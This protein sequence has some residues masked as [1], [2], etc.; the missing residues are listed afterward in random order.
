MKLERLLY[1]K[2][3]DV[4][5]AQA[6]EEGSHTL[7]RCLGPVQLVTLGVGCII[8]AGIFVL[9]G[10]AAHEHAGP[11]IVLSFVLAGIVS[12]LAALCYAELASMIPV[13]GSAYTYA[14]ATLGQLFAWIIAWDLIV[15]YLFTASTVA[16]GWSG[17]FTGLMH[18]IGIHV[19]AAWSQA[20]YTTA[21]DGFGLVAT[22]AIINLPAA[23]IIALTSFVLALGVSE[24]SWLNTAMVF[25]KVGVVLLVIVFGF[26][27]V[28]ASNWTPFIPPATVDAATGATHYGM[29]GVVTAAGVI[30][31]A[32]IGFESV[33]TAAQEAVNPQRNMPIGILGALAICTVLYIL[34]CLVITG[35]VPYSDPGLAE[36][37]PI[38]TVVEA[39]GPSYI[40]LKFVVTVGAT[41]GLGSTILVLLYGQ[42]RIFYSMS[43]DGLLPAGF[44]S[45]DPKRR[46]PVMGTALTALL[47]GLMAGLF[48]IGLLGELVSVGTLLAFAMICAGVMY[49]RIRHPE[50]PRSFRTP[51]WWLTAPLGVASCLYLIAS[52]PVATFWRLVVW[53]GIGL[54]IYA[55]YAY[56]HARD[57]GAAAPSTGSAASSN[58]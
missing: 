21:A 55:L 42:S 53:M 31:F 41:I 45:I 29:S 25:V 27:F 35:V 33:S 48:P 13:S 36:P 51:V 10:H 28:D 11:G 15:E 9:T 46:T 49:L 52:L 43:R 37:R 5:L 39:M 7:R 8:G 40:W 6:A 56:G 19:P 16:V 18:D 26:A 3:I 22:G 50:I 1:R 34:M 23:F 24:S 20:P 12:A 47:G 44:G 38:Y 58:T 54:A 4:L 2:P 57:F 17:Y 30:F 32:Y 14:Y